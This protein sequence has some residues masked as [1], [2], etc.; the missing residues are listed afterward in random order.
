MNNSWEII[1]LL[2]LLM[3]S[4]LYHRKY[5]IVRYTILYYRLTIAG[6]DIVEEIDFSLGAQRP[7][8]FLEHKL[9]RAI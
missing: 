1:K 7:A 6:S 5:C 2:K 9:S 8:I 4:N 3:V